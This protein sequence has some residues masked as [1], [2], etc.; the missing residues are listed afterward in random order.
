[1]ASNGTGSVSG[2]CL[3]VRPGHLDEVESRLAELPWVDVHARDE[4]TSRLVVVQEQPTVE[5]HQR[6]LRELQAVAN[7]LT[8][9][10][11]VHRAFEEE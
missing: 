6:G 3:M 9:D 1:M 2:L 11:V 4:S 10:L 5:D 8:A 7:V